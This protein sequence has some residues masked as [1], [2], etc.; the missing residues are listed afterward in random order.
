MQIPVY[1][2]DILIEADIHKTVKELCHMSNGEKC[3]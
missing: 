3:T 1:S 2:A